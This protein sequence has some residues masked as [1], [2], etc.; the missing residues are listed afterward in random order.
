MPST[1]EGIW[2]IVASI[3][4]TTITIIIIAIV[5]TTIIIAIILTVNEKYSQSTMAGKKG[6]KV[7]RISRLASHKTT[8]DT[9][10]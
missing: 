2:Q 10:S 1:R 9:P 6:V 5:K 7:F 8:Y 3:K 4:T